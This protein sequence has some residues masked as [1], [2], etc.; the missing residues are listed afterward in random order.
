MPFDAKSWAAKQNKHG[1]AG[2]LWTPQ[3]SSASLTNGT[4]GAG[5]NEGDPR[6]FQREAFIN[7]ESGTD[8]R[9]A[10]TE[11]YNKNMT[12]ADGA[13]LVQIRD[14]KRVKDWSLVT[15]NE[16]TGVVT[17]ESNIIDDETFIDK[18]GVWA[19]AAIPAAA[20][21]AGALGAGGGAGAAG[22]GELA[23]G[24][25]LDLV[26]AGPGFALEGGVA[27]AGGAAAAGGGAAAAGGAGAAGTGAAGAGS[28]VLGS[29]VSASQIARGALGLAALGQSGSGGGGG[30]GSGQPT[31]ASA[32]IEQMANANRVDMNTPLGS[33]KWNKGADGRWSVNDSMNPA[34]QANFENVQ[35]MNADVTGM[36]RQRLAEFL[37]NPSKRKRADS[38]INFGGMTLGG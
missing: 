33:R 37:A 4:G 6:Y 17:P 13:R 32:I 15:E 24:A 16:E 7:G 26:G 2:L 9:N 34:E 30:G 21:A 20:M 36:G 8:Y 35:G 27:G 19:L 3:Q 23:A 11:L 31:D 29:G 28:G 10:P 25:G 1:R 5:Y 22:A 18:Y 12:G 38:P 14:P